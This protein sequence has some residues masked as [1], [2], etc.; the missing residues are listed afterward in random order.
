[1]KWENEMWRLMEKTAQG[2]V[3]ARRAVLRIE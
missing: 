2:M 3:V 1:M